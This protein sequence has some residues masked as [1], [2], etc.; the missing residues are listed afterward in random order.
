MC[1]II[2]SAASF[3]FA[4]LHEIFRLDHTFVCL[5]LPVNSSVRDIMEAM[6]NSSADYVLVKMNSSG[7]R[8]SDALHHQ[9]SSDDP[10]GFSVQG[11]RSLNC[12]NDLS[13]KAVVG[14]LSEQ[15]AYC[16]LHLEL[17]TVLTV[18]RRT[19]ACQKHCMLSVTQWGR[20]HLTWG[21]LPKTSF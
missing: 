5:M 4:V 15:Y 19:Q 11:H 6:T 9:M 8:L 21:P 20:R 7:G 3:F 2:W 13:E 12:R 17:T 16:G 10:S 18:C 1:N 14:H